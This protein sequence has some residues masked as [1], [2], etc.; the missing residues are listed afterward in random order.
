MSRSNDQA[1]RVGG[2]HELSFRACQGWLK[3]LR[4]IRNLA[5]A[6]DAG[7]GP[8]AQSAEAGE[9]S[10]DWSHHL[11][12]HTVRKNRRADEHDEEERACHRREVDN[13]DRNLVHERRRG[14]VCQGSNDDGEDGKA[15]GL[16]IHFDPFVLGT[17]GLCVHHTS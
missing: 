6:S 10:P 8:G 14:E 17:R 12:L 4:A 9:D 5:A 15:N 7:H 2:R 1:L 3:G 11:G 13:Q 16:G